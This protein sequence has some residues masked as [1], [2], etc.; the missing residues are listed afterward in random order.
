[1]A[2][3]TDL[4]RQGEALA[5]E[6]LESKGYSVLVRNYRYQKAEVDLIVQKDSAQLVFVEVKTRT[7]DFF[8]D[9]Q[10]FVTPAQIKNIVAAAHHYITDQDL[11]VEARF[12]IVAVLKNTQTQRV[13]HFE[14]AFYH[15]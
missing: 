8:G 1:M 5:V 3:H 2:Q 15:F 4:G 10:S 9:P 7:S 6:Y 14:D 13:E 12:D 11:D